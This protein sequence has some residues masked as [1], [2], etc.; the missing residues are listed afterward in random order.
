MRKPSDSL[1]CFLDW[2]LFAE[3]RRI[4]KEILRWIG[5]IVAVRIALLLWRLVVA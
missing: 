1:F 2:L 5:L 3:S 4:T